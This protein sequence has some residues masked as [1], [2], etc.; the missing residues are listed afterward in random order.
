MFIRDLDDAKSIFADLEGSFSGVGITAFSRIIPSYFLQAYQILALRETGDFS[1]IN[2]QV[3]MFCLERAIGARVAEKGFNSS[4]LLSAQQAKAFLKNRPDPKYLLLYQNY[5][6]LEA[7][8]GIEGWQLLSNPSSLRIKAAQRPFFYQMVKE[9]DLPG[10]P[11]GIFPLKALYAMGYETWADQMGPRFVV[12]LPEIIQGGGRGTFFIKSQ[13]G[14]GDFLEYLRGGSWRENEITCASVHQYI[15]GTPVS[16]ALCVTKH[17]ILCSGLQ[18]QLMDLAYCGDIPED[19]V[20]C[21]HSWGETPW[22]SHIR[23]DAKNQGQRIGRYLSALGY[24]G[25]FGVDFIIEEG[26]GKRVIPLEVNPRFTGAFPML[27]QCHMRKQW[28]PLDAFHILEFLGAP[29]QVDVEGMNEIYEGT[30]RGGHLVLFDRRSGVRKAEM[31]LKAGMYGYD[32]KGGAIS[33]LKEALDFKGVKQE[34]VFVVVECPSEKSWKG[35][36]SDDPFSRLCRLIF[37]R[38]IADDQ[39]RLT[40]EALCAVNW[41][42]EQ[43][44]ENIHISSVTKT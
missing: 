12:Q 7:L 5:A 29:Y 23:R 42:Y 18:R 41:A 30:I 15:E 8:A 19:G 25:I 11:G 36:A 16:L 4:R 28:V 9:L 35:P 2:R 1:I 22:P 20:F 24:R 31:S 38:P 14:Y 44:F 26:A 21:G 17:G 34:N 43:M 39:G 40:G 10:N 13:G 37:P 3:E 27:S 32:V 6:E 33:F